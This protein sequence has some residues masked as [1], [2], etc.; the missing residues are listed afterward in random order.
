MAGFLTAGFSLVGQENLQN[1][2]GVVGPDNTP[3]VNDLVTSFTSPGTFGGASPKNS[4]QTGKV[5]LV[6][7][8]GG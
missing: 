6:G 5:I 3:Q 2:G 8:G 1:D 7:G 4:G